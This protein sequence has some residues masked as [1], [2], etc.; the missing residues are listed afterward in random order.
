M[1]EKLTIILPFLDSDI[2][3]RDFTEKDAGE[4]EEFFYDFVKEHED[5]GLYQY[6]NILE[7]NGLAWDSEVMKNA[8]VSKLD[9]RTVLALI[10][11]AIRADHF[12]DGALMDF[13]ESGSI[14][15][16]LQR[17]KQIDLENARRDMV[18]IVISSGSG[19]TPAVYAYRDK[20]TI[21]RDKIEYENIPYIESDQNPHRKWAYRTNNPDFA[22]LYDELINAV[23]EIIHR[24]EALLLIV[25]DATQITFTVTYTDKTKESRS[26]PLV[27]DSFDKCFAIAQKMVPAVERI[28]NAILICRDHEE[29]DD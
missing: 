28:P 21:T 15:K 16:W 10:M 3:G 12:C 23:F 5:L 25:D 22:Q 11:G 4:F 26:Y 7:E 27:D 6:G 13:F 8:D 2:S 17:L 18:R 24:D 29:D 20:L 19:Y 1:Y 14:Q 9:G